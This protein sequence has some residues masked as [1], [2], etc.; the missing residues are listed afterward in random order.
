MYL[1]NK[2]YPSQKKKKQQKIYLLNLIN[3]VNIEKKMLNI[4]KL[5]L[6]NNKYLSTKQVHKK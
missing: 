5:S 6:I 3:C 1:S 4:Y 2:K